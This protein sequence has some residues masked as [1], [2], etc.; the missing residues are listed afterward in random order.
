MKPHIAAKSNLYY[1]FQSHSAT[2]SYVEFECSF[3]NFVF[4]TKLQDLF[5]RRLKIR[6][7]AS[8][9][10]PR[11]V[12]L[13]LYVHL[14]SKNASD[15]STH[16]VHSSWSFCCNLNRLAQLVVVLRYMLFRQLY[17][18]FKITQS[19]F[20]SYPHFSLHK[21]SVSVTHLT[22]QHLLIVEESSRWSIAVDL[23]WSSL[24]HQAALGPT[25][26]TG[27]SCENSVLLP[28]LGVGR[29]PPLPHSPGFAA[30]Q[31][32]L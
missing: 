14:Y 31:D 30:I 28:V 4:L 2:N 32:T 23:S 13:K 25:P 9:A 8:P 1:A 16:L 19:K 22:I 3:E 11:L 29:W 7:K 21:N 20:W 12:E 17:S 15:M 27:P 6:L 26:A 24:F 10:D 5:Y 18:S